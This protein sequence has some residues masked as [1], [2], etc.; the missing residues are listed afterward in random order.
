MSSCVYLTISW[1]LSIFID[2]S[3]DI[4]SLEGNGNSSTGTFGLIK[5]IVSWQWE[6]E[7]EVDTQTFS[8]CL[9]MVPLQNQL[10]GKSGHLGLTYWH[11]SLSICGLFLILT[12]FWYLIIWNGWSFSNVF[13]IER[14]TEWSVMEPKSSLTNASIDQGSLSL[15]CFSFISCSVSFCS[16]LKKLHSAFTAFCSSLIVLHWM[17]SFPNHCLCFI[18][19]K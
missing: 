13:E 5:K 7:L 11:R 18:Y 8:E 19:E 17:V 9:W 15:L 6:N 1:F 4:L 2:L 14:E 10:A 16:S 12:F 3:I